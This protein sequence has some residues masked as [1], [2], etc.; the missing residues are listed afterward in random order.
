M[1]DFG[2]KIAKQ[3]Y[4]VLDAEPKDLV[5]SSSY[6]CLKI[7]R[8]GKVSAVNSSEITFDDI[9]EFPLVILVFLY[10]SATSKY[11]PVEVEFDSTKLYLDGGE[12]TGSYYYYFICYA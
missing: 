5:F 3:G 9:I 10:N 1:A 12:A 8:L 7:L 6:P 4:N 11:E 2:L